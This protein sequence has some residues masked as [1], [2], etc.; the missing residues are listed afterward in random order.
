MRVRG[1]VVL[2]IVVAVGGTGCVGLS[3]SPSARFFVLRPL[4]EPVPAGEANRGLVGVM[5]V[6]IPDHLE[7]PQL[8]TWIA[9][10]EL[11]IDEFLRW[12]EPLDAGLLRTLSENL[13]AL[14]P[15]YFVLRSPWPSRAAPTCRVVAELTT[16]GLQPD[17]G[18]LLEGRWA[19][20]PPAAERPLVTRSARLRRGPLPAGPSG[21]NPTAQ[22]DALSE[23]I[24]D[25]SREIAAAVRALPEPPKDAPPGR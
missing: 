17:G 10:G 21:S 20:L 14:L 16:F 8:V 7:R 11:H 18:V 23:L 1:L 25:L 24:A 9:P 13:Q 22:M 4:A 6:R 5:P 3:R 12:G 15:E 19:L 2:S